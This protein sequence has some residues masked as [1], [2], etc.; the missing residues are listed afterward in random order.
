MWMIIK[1]SCKTKNWK[2]NIEKIL[3]KLNLVIITF[4]NYD[5]VITNVCVCVYVWKEE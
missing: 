1:E 3:F 4:V 5:L 2:K